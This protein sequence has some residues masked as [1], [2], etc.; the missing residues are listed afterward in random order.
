MD[1]LEW[2]AAALGEEAVTAGVLS[3]DPELLE[4]ARA[5]KSGWAAD[6]LPLAIVS[7]RTVEHVQTTLRAASEFRVPVV[8]RGAGTGLA[9]GANGTD[10]SIVLDVSGMNRILE[11][12]AEDQLAVVE[13]GVINSDLN[14]ALE[15]YGLFF[16]PDPA[17]RAVSTV[18]G[19]IAT[20]AGGLLCAK[21]GVTREAVLGLE[22]VLADGRLLSTGHRTVKGVTGYDLTA[23]FVGSEGTLGVIVGATVRLQPIP[24]G[25]PVTLGALFP[26]V[27]TAAEASARVTAARLRPAVMELLDAPALERIAAHLGRETLEEAFGASDGAAYLLVQFDGATAA[28]D[29]EAAGTLIAETGGTV[30]VA[31]DAAEGERLLALRRAFHPAL[32]ASGEVL[33][34]DVAVPR[35]RMPEMF[36]AIERISTRYGIPIPTVAHAGDGNLHPN[37]VYTGDEVPAVVWDAANDLFRTAIELGGTLTGEHGVG[38]LKRRWLADEVGPDSYEL[39]V[40]LKSVFDPLGIL[41]PGKVFG[42]R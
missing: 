23:L 41:N 20:N 9:G 11:I 19:N 26:D 14:A 32:A 7:A 40:K 34:E 5:D 17:S 16:A 1:V 12:D 31:A 21:Y 2:L 38:V 22:V 10:G 29:A 37:F 18:G 3:T 15:P 4:A 6:G 42:G 27:R 33:I 24:P 13:P 25:E 35:S 28:A 39:Q 8:P 30:R 36:A